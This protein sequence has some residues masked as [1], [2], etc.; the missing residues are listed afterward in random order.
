MHTH[1]HTHTVT[2]THTHTH[3][4]VHTHTHTRKHCSLLLQIYFRRTH[5]FSDYTQVRDI[6]KK[7]ETAHVQRLDVCRNDC[8]VYWDSVHLE[9]ADSYRHAH[10]T[11]CPV[12]NAPRFV[13][14]PKNGAVKASKVF[15]YFPVKNFLRSLFA[16]PDIVRHLLLDCGERPEVRM[17][18]VGVKI[19][20]FLI[21]FWLT[22]NFVVNNQLSIT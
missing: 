20:M 7:S 17:T 21:N 11:K 5:P 1:I 8:I 10:R 4:R 14:D 12:C 2:H 22:Q 15:F 6:L 9:V 19:V 18:I 16:R 3:K 13:T